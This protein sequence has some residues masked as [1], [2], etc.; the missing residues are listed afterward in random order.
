M[1]GAPQKTE[2]AD[3]K[4]LETHFEFGANWESFASGISEDSILEAEQGLLRLLG[5][6]SIA[7]KRFIDIGCGS[8]IHG[9]AAL[10]LGAAE[11]VCCDIDPVSV[12]TAQAVLGRYAPGQ[13][14]QAR[15]A[16]VFDLTPETL[17]H[18]D[19]VYSWGVLHHTGSLDLAMRRAA[20]LLANGGIF[21]FALYR[22]TWMCSFWTVEKRWYTGASTIMQRLARGIYSTLFYVGLLVTGRNPVRYVSTYHNRRGMD[23]RHDVHDWLGGYPYES[24]SPQDVNVL[25]RSL[26]LSEVRSFVQSGSRAKCGLLGSGC[27]EY[28]YR[29]EA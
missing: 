14:W 9:L 28:V 21:V 4:S 6:T 24:I 16:S 23:F 1:T 22:K 17:G 19:I 7:G 10:R 20:A 26:H 27:D 11:V 29:R 13:P 15:E 8:G 12:S 18:F 5:E 2:A 25:M 3:L